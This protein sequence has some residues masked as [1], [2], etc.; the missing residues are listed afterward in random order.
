[1]F[2][3]EQYT[4]FFGIIFFKVIKLSLNHSDFQLCVKT[5]MLDF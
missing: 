2:I 5:Q 1:M 4:K 3:T